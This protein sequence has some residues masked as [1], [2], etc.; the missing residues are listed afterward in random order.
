MSN[1]KHKFNF[2]IKITNTRDMHPVLMQAFYV[3]PRSIRRDAWWLV[4]E[5]D[6][7]MGRSPILPMTKER[8]K[9]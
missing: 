9:P 1:D 8:L 2:K 3:V 6:F 5:P 7:C 4:D